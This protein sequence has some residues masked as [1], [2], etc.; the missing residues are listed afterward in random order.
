M[1]TLKFLMVSTHFPPEHLGGDAVFVEYLS[2]ELL[3]RGHEVH[4]FHSPATYRLLRGKQRK[5]TDRR[6]PDGLT[7]HPYAS[8]TGR[9]DPLLA[10]SLGLW[11]RATSGLLELEKKIGP[12]V[13]HWHNTRGFIGRPFPFEGKISL[14]TTH[15]YTPVCPRSNLLKPDISLCDDP[16]FCTI[17]CMRWRR[18]PQLW[19]TGGR[20]VLRY[21]DGL[22]IL[23]PS[24]FMAA[25]LRSEGVP[26]HKVMR[27]FVPDLGG[28][29]RRD[30]AT[31]DTI[32]Y[33]GLMEKHKGIE[34]LLDAF[35]RTMDQQGFRLHMIGEG[36]LRSELLKRT[37][38]AGLG[39]R[40]SIP[41]FLSRGEVERIRKDAAA[42]V[43]PSIWYE[44]A[45]S[46]AAEAL[47]L[48]LPVI[49]SRIGGL[50]E[51]VGPE[52]GS[53]T[54]EP[55]DSA[56]L[57]D[58]LVSLWSDRG[59]M[60]ERRRKARAAYEKRF[61]PHIHLEEYLKTIGELSV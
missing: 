33:L 7:T 16:R 53:V 58:L 61:A 30:Q 39:G 59:G 55:G 34:T 41:G 8:A 22:K 57:G 45:P 38:K 10:L 54:F 24:E 14:Y 26:V 47:S 35:L 36:T 2:N 11:G 42:Q 12:D 43:I 40:I 29:F 52:S 18:P 50:P 28:D 23:C 56:E 32:V 6:R 19:R 49:A 1:E 20:R 9:A 60:G 13:V 3:K 5:N 37:G 46:V 21:D 51:M 15:D 27:L 31:G 44:N 4:V 48:G 17:C 25:R